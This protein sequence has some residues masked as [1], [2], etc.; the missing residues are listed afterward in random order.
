MSAAEQQVE[1][2]PEGTLLDGKFR[3]VRCVGTGGMGAVYEIRHEITRHRR[4][5][6]LLHK[7]WASDR[8]AVDRFLRE[9]SVAGRIENP[10]ITETF[11]AGWLASGDPYV[12]MEYLEGESLADRLS[13]GT[14]LALEEAVRIIAEACRGM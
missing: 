6:K 3:I 8:E 7:G 13:G 12:V 5:L 11:D 4:A 9:A 2:L 1:T 14:P 10:H